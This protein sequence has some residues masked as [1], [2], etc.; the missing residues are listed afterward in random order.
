MLSDHVTS[1]LT[2]ILIIIELALAMDGI[3]KKQRCAED[4]KGDEI[5]K[6]VSLIESS[7]EILF[8]SDK[9]KE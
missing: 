4:L 6:L 7:K 2:A 3:G 1:Q 5:E 8:E 9:R